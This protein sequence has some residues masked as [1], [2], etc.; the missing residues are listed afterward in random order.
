MRL[1]ELCTLITRRARDG[2]LAALDGVLVS[3]VEEPSPPTTTTS[4]V[5]FALIAQGAKS[6][7]LGD[8]I[9][10]YRAGQYLVASLDLPVTGQFTEASPARPHSASA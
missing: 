10:E 6:L 4:G 2:G 5:V 8:R 1:D 3:L 7:A 9:F